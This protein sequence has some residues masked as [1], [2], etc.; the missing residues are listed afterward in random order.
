VSETLYRLVHDHVQIVIG[1]VLFLPIEPVFIGAVLRHAIG[2]PETE[3]ID[4][5][6]GGHREFLGHDLILAPSQKFEIY[7][8]LHIGGRH[9]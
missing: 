6:I 2:C 7:Y 8:N 1:Y 9:S 3:G 5:V 4:H